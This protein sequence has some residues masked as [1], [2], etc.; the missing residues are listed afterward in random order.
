M[1]YRIALIAIASVYLINL[2]ATAFGIYSVWPYFDIPMH[3]LGGLTV[4]L[5]GIALDKQ[6]K[7]KSGMRMKT[8]ARL[9]QF[10]FVLGF[11]MTVAVVWEF[12]E[13]INDHTIGVWNGWT[14][15]Q[16]PSLGDTMKDL[17]MGGIGGSLSVLLTQYK[18]VTR[19]KK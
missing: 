19:S 13:Y 1:S 6:L 17:L 9:H 14:N 15:A 4:G 12:H 10:I 7:E 2:I 8:E 18:N 5:L 11:V 16:Q 3:F